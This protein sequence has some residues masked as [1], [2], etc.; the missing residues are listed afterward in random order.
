[1][2]WIL[3]SS[4][5]LLKSPCSSSWNLGENHDKPVDLGVP[6]ELCSDKP[7][8]YGINKYGWIWFQYIP[9]IYIYIPCIYIYIFYIYIYIFFK[10]YIYMLNLSTYHGYL[11]VET[12]FKKYKISFG[13]IPNHRNVLFLQIFLKRAAKPS[14][15]LLRNLLRNHLT[16][17]R[18]KASRNLLR[19][20]LRNPGEP[21][22]TLHRS[23][24]H[25]LRTFA[26]TLLNLT[27]L[28]TTGSAPKPPR[29]SPEPSPE[30]PLNVTW[31]CNKASQTFGTFC[32]TW[33]GACTSAQGAILGWRP[34]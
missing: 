23:L 4:F 27:W 2:T 26:R 34:H 15:D 12:V 20:L 11:D 30:P 5:L 3:W 10:I 8:M 24:P 13:G 32:W 14:P 16:W 1:M 17:L 25:L 19:K 21:N 22:L 18:T 31:L 29:P 9:C 7:I 6:C 33:P 28:C